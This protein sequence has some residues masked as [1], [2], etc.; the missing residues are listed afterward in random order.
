VPNKK[1]K[2]S[3]FPLQLG[4]IEKTPFYAKRQRPEVI[5][6]LCATSS[7]SGRG[8]DLA[9]FLASGNPVKKPHSFPDIEAET[10]IA[11][12]PYAHKRSRAHPW[13]VY[14]ALF[15]NPVKSIS[16]TSSV[17]SLA[18]VAVNPYK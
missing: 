7:A 6:Y 8:P 10:A 14:F 13:F 12:P 1:W 9:I 3:R 4:A 18:F 17:Q 5:L 2:P 11:K 15:A 16:N